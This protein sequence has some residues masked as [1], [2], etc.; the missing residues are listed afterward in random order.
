MIFFYSHLK[1]ILIKLE[2]TLVIKIQKAINLRAITKTAMLKF[3]RAYSLTNNQS[4]LLTL[5]NYQMPSL[6]HI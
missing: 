4:I 1:Q 5:G 6:Y 2:K 3:N